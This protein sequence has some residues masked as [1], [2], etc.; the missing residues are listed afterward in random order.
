MTGALNCANI[1]VSA[2][3]VTFATG[4]TPT[5]VVNGSMTL[6]AG[7]VWSATGNITFTGNSLSTLTSNGT[8]FSSTDIT[9]NN[10][11]AGCSLGS[12]LNT[13]NQ[14]VYLTAGSLNLNGFNITGGIFSSSNSNV[15]SINFGANYFIPT[16]AGSTV[17]SM[18]TMTN[19]TFTGTG[20]FYLTTAT[21]NRQVQCGS[22]SNTGGLALTPGPNLF[23]TAGSGTVTTIIGDFS[24]F[25]KIDFTG[26]VSAAPSSKVFVD[27]LV[28]SSGG[29]FTNFQP[30]F[31][32]TQTWTAQFSKQLGGI[33]VSIPGGTLTLDG[34]QTFTAT[35]EV[36]VYAGTLDLGGFDVTCGSFASSVTNT[37][38][39]AFGSNNI[40]LAHTTAATVNLSVADATNFSWTGT[41]GFTAAASLTR[42]YTFGTTG[43]LTTNAPNLT[44]TGSGT[45]I[46][47]F[48]SSSWFNNLNFTSTA[49]AVPTTTLNVNSVTLSSAASA[50]YTNLSINM[51]GTGS[52]TNSGKTISLLTVNTAGT[53]TLTAALTSGAYTQ[54]AGTL[55][56]AGFNFTTGPTVFQGGTLSNTGT[57]ACTTFSV[58]S[59]TFTMTNGTISPSTSFTINSNGTFN[60]NGGTLTTP[61][62]NHTYGTVTLGQAL[63]LP[64]TVTYTLGEGTLN[65]NGYNL[66]TGIFSSNNVNPRSVAFGSNYIYLATTT[67]FATVLDM[68]GATNF[69]CTGTGGFSTAMSVAR[70]VNFGATS[71][72]VTPIPSPNLFVTS[73][74]SAL[75]IPTNA[76]FNNLD[77]TGSTC[78]STGFVFVDTLT[79]A[80]GGTYTGLIP[81]FT[82]T[83]TWTAQF[84]KQLG[85]IGVAVPSGTLTLD[86]TQTYTSTSIF[87]LFRGQLDLG[88][89]DL[90]IGTFVNR[91]TDTRSIAFGS[92]NIILST[93]VAAATNLS[94][95]TA[96]GFTWTGTGGFTADASITRTFTFGT[97][98]GTAANAP[99]LTITGAGT[100]IQT[101]SSGSWFK[102]LNFESTAFVLPATALNLS[103]FT[104]SAGGTFTGLTVTTVGTGTL[105]TN[106]KPIAALTINCPGA[107]TT[108]G[109]AVTFGLATATTT[110]TAG[111][112]ALNGYDI[113]TG[114]FSSSNTNVRA[115]AFG[116]NQI[117][118]ATTTAA[119]TNLSMAI[120]TNFSCT[121]SGTGSSSNGFYALSDITRTFTCGTTA[122]PTVAPN[123]INGGAGTA[124]LTFTTGSY[125]GTFRLGAAFTVPATSL[126]VNNFFANGSASVSSVNITMIGTDGTFQLNSGNI[127]SLTINTSGTTT[128][129]AATN[130][131]LGATTLTSGTLDLNGKSFTTATFSSDNSN[132]RAVTFGSSYIITNTATASTTNVAMATST[133][134][135]CS[136]TGGFAATM[137]TTRTFTCGSTATTLTPPNLFL[138]S[139]ASVASITNSSVFNKID[140][141][142]CTFAWGANTI[143]C[144]TLYSPSTSSTTTGL[145]PL[146][147][148]TGTLTFNGVGLRNLY[149]NDIASTSLGLPVGTTTLGSNVTCGATSANLGAGT[150]NLNGFNLTCS[151]FL[152]S[153]TTTR[154]V[155]F[156]TGYIITTLTTSGGIRVDMANASGFTATGTGGF[157]STQNTVSNF[158][159]G[160]TTPPI[161][162]PNYF[163]AGGTSSLN[164]SGYFGTIDLS[165]QSTGTGS[166][167]SGNLKSLVLSS[168]GSYTTADPVFF[169]PGGTITSN[170]ASIRSI[171]INHSGTTT[172]ASS[173]TATSLTLTQGTLNLS[174]SNITVGTFSSSGT[175]VRSIIGDG[176]G[177]TAILVTSAGAAWT[178]TDGTNFTGSGYY[179]RMA[180]DS[181][182]TFAG[183]GGSYGQLRQYGVSTGV[184]TVT[185]SNS[186]TDI[187]ATQVPATITF[188]AGT[189]QTVANFTLSG[190]SGFPVTINSTVSGSQFTLSKAS[191]TVSV[192]YLSIRDSNVTGGAYWGT[193]TSTFVSNNTGWNP[194][195]PTG[196]FMAFF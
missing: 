39:I 86:G 171:T 68:D 183:G 70:T 146:M 59:G 162:A 136:G 138:F 123:F 55:D 94:V 135:S 11:V 133:N 71:N 14:T 5:L 57:L 15:R 166:S 111:T 74:A 28:L 49:F 194:V 152:S 109:G 64:G 153:F 168:V 165:N 149:V 52:I 131:V 170:G 56:F 163:N 22:T 6:V 143:F 132:V 159:I 192:N 187:Q 116:T 45:S 117:N 172:L 73:G 196:N 58:S 134:F 161:V 100:A 50:S 107:T 99:N 51:R 186:F 154:Q 190:A 140:T 31:T 191:G 177:G 102:N 169:Y 83:Q 125:F 103:G 174:S 93:T 179:I 126:F 1:T 21:A 54:T 16:V 32:R 155:D 78:A 128:L 139:G 46:Q 60:Y 145:R 141:G 144:Q 151:Q 195:R 27:T 43:G 137:S 41:G 130:V 142:T 65:L 9:F 97:T 91:T 62:F 119:A 72:V 3:T 124:V 180:S 34:T 92:N 89:F 30:I 175:A 69:T 80:T 104:L 26:L 7:T 147:Y 82:R 178:V 23:I 77:F 157:Y 76:S 184:L 61:V 122:A 105:T 2:G 188:T 88:G 113:T 13:N 87:S 108:L 185:G 79:L 148:G 160:T 66:T 37:R 101:L 118:L 63:T 173:V 81:S 75:T 25:N 90:T 158:N 176:G 129:L 38:S 44:L 42:T 193:T 20:G 112:L 36:G 156:S 85:G 182:K 47:T 18:A 48:T 110:L 115:I 114:I 24:S 10:T 164:L 35:S 127:A 8:Q 12:A 19:A 33:G 167:F 95:V 67:A 84:S 189:T 96:T 4:T 106:N 29:T 17:V 98:G 121:S 150:L 40:I 181:P 120:A 53:A